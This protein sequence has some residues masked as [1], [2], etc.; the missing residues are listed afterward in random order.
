M[1]KGLSIRGQST[2]LH[3]CLFLT[4]NIRWACGQV[5]W[6]LPRYAVHQ[7]VG[8]PQSV[9]V[10]RRSCRRGRDSRRSGRLTRGRLRWLSSPNISKYSL[11]VLYS[12]SRKPLK[13]EP[14]AYIS[15][16]LFCGPR[17]NQSE[18]SESR[19]SGGN[20]VIDRQSHEEEIPIACY[21]KPY[22]CSL[23]VMEL[24]WSAGLLVGQQKRLLW[25]VDW[26]LKSPNL[27]NRYE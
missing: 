24:F 5:W 26:I 21:A 9:G 27:L 6:R 2:I 19:P 15:V 4:G 10:L 1:Y 14:Q 16:L 13:A 7:V 25:W 11:H 18:L 3:F 17:A 20:N 22:L 23:K 8:E 12:F